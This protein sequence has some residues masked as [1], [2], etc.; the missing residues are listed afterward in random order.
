MCS[1]LLCLHALHALRA[2][3]CWLITVQTQTFQ[4]PSAD[5]NMSYCTQ[6]LWNFASV[7]PPLLL[8]ISE[9]FLQLVLSPSVVNSMIGHRDTR[10]SVCQPADYIRAENQTQSSEAGIC[11]GTDLEMTPGTSLLL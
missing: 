2:R 7:V 3:L 8:L 10:L 6:V 4:T 1:H 9:M 11:G 5:E